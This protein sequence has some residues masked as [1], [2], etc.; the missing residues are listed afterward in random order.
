MHADVTCRS[1]VENIAETGIA[2]FG[3]INFQL[4]SAGAN[5]RRSTFLVIDELL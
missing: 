2:Y 1:S 3:R 5:F 4:N